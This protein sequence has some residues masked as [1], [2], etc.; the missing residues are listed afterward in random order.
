MEVPDLQRSKV[1]IAEDSI[2]VV[3]ATYAKEHEEWSE[4]HWI[5]GPSNLEYI[6][7]STR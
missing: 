5:L 6:D 7:S 3:A 4:S 1:D 2:G